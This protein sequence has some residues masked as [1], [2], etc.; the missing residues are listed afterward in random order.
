[1]LKTRYHYFSV[2]LSDESGKIRSAIIQS[3]SRCVTAAIIKQAYEHL[4]FPDTA[5][6]ISVSWLGKMTQNEYANGVKARSRN[7]VARALLPWVICALALSV[8]I[9][10]HFLRN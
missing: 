7:E 8:T 3:R 6:L 9:A 10:G 5:V 2:C 4:S 1:M